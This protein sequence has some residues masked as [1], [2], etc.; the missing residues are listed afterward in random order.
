MS[1]AVNYGVS[2]RTTVSGTVDRGSY[3]VLWSCPT[4]DNK[5][6][7]SA[8]ATTKPVAKASAQIVCISPRF[9]PHDG[10]TGGEPQNSPPGKIAG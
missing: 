6:A 1:V 4:D 7:T 8:K 3:I 10:Q 5:N 2:R 9:K